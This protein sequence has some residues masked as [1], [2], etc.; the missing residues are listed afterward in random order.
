MDR[1][2]D[3][4]KRWVIDTLLWEFQRRRGLFSAGVWRIRK[5]FPKVELP[6]LEFLGWWTWG[7]GKSISH[8]RNI[9]KAEIGKY[10]E[11]LSALSRLVWL[12]Q[13]WGGD[14]AKGELAPNGRTGMLCSFESH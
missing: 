8:G 3:V 12:Q 5:A 2:V 6:E 7:C 1:K 9:A 14:K 13:R 10:R 11:H 4:P